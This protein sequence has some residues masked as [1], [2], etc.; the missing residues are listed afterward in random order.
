MNKS[1]SVSLDKET[2]DR[3]DELS[4]KFVRDRGYTP[5]CRSKVI[6]LS[7]QYYYEHIF[8]EE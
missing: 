6:R 2:L 3:I 8:R 1:L 5:S 7:V 4:C